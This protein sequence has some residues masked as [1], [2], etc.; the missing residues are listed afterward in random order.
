MTP[1]SNGQHRLTERRRQHWHD[2]E[3][4]HGDGHDLR[5]GRT[6]VA[7]AH[8][9]DDQ[10]ARRGR[11]HALQKARPE[12]Q[13]EARR[14]AGQQSEPGI[15][16]HGQHHQPFAPE[17]VRQRPIGKLRRAEPDQV[18][19][20]D[21]LPPILLGHRQCFPDRWQRRQHGVDGKRVGRH[22]GGHQHHEFTCA[23]A[24]SIVRRNGSV[25]HLHVLINPGGPPRTPGPVTSSAFLHGWR[26]LR[27]GA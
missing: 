12:Q 16:D 4:D 23:Q 2:H 18:D 24:S 22:Q 15:E 1:A 7:I 14:K 17:P 26:C 8:D 13:L 3:D 27:R 6:L 10:H 9:G 25:G 5:H 21:Q 20:D 11:R 19:G